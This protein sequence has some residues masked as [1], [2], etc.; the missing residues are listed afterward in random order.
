MTGTKKLSTALALLA[1]S[2]IAFAA[3]IAHAEEK[4]EA[5]CIGIDLGTTYSVVGVWQHDKVEII[6]NEMGNRITPSVV[7]FTDDERL[8]GDAARNQLEVNYKNTIY[9]VKRLMGRQYNDDSVQKDKK[10][11][12]YEV[13]ADSHG[14]AAVQVTFKGEKK[15]FKPEQ[16]STNWT[17]VWDLLSPSSGTGRMHIRILGC[18]QRGSASA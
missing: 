5:P 2:V 7:A 13:V 10:V 17:S 6:A 1:V 18:T 12:S 11:L 8:V 4:V 16:A 3:V 14:R 15:T 9:A